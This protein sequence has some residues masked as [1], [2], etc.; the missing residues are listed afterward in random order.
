MKEGQRN[1][2]E[3]RKTESSQQHFYPTLYNQAERV[4]NCVW[5]SG[6]GKID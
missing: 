5:T 1:N 4:K 2:S 6:T 3:Y